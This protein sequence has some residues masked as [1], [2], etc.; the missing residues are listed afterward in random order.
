MQSFLKSIDK[1]AGKSS[2]I[3]MGSVVNSAKRR[4]TTYSDVTRTDAQSREIKDRFN[5]RNY[6]GGQSFE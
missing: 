3:S 4:G 5:S 1:S 2:K 6:K